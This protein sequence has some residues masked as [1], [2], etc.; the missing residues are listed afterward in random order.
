MAGDGDPAA[1]SV[2]ELCRRCSDET[3]RYRSGEPHEDRFCLDLFRRAIVERGEECWTG[4][5]AIYAALVQGWCRAARKT[6][7]A[8]LDE[9]ATLSWERFWRAYTPDRFARATGTRSILKYLQLCV[10]SAAADQFRN[11]TW[12]RSLDEQI[13]QG[14]DDTTTWAS[15]TADPQP[16]PSEIVDEA[17]SVAELWA[18]IDRV[19][20]TEIER[21]V[22]R[23]ALGSGLRSREVQQQR[24]DLF[25][26]VEVVYTTTRTVYDRLRRNPELDRKSVV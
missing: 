6:P 15:L 13:P 26:S 21:V 10:W 24:P 23:L 11:L 25:P 9:L 22:L 16:H 12:H 3:A 14:D 20:R 1:L 5:V 7:T 2:A 8:D 18:I 4:L 19:A 17:E